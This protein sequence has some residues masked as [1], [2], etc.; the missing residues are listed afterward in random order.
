MNFFFLK[1][2]RIIW[3]LIKKEKLTNLPPLEQMTVELQ[4]YYFPEKCNHT[5]YWKNHGE[6]DKYVDKLEKDDLKGTRTK[7]TR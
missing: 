3:Y 6:S 4:A 5:D 2:L 7:R 1:W